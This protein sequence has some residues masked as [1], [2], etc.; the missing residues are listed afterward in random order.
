MHYSEK[1]R[2][3]RNLPD[4]L[5]KLKFGGLTSTNHPLILTYSPH[6]SEESLKYIALGLIPTSFEVISE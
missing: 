3:V 5:E 1:K 6:W 2:I 4:S